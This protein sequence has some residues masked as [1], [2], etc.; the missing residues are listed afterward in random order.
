MSRA[1]KPV[2]PP[3]DRPVRRRDPERT[4]AR[5]LEAA[6][7]Q[8]SQRAYPYVGVRDIAAQ[9]GVDVSMAF[10]YFGSKE[11]LFEAAFASSFDAFD[12]TGEREAF[13]RHVVGLFLDEHDQATLPLHII[14]H[15]AADPVASEAIRRIARKEMVEPI[16]EW[17]GGPDAEGRAAQ[18][19]ALCAGFFTYRVL[20]P[21]APFV[22]RMDAKAR[23]WLEGALQAVVDG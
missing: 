13:G 5:L 12:L 15:A 21:L 10:R 19:L 18:I 4:K 14:Q 7:Q 22:G 8:F 6:R 11:G 3:P 17:L 23:A 16:A 9:A 2:D 20:V 1:S